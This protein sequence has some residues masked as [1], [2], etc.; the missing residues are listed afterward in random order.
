MSVCGFEPLDYFRNVIVAI[1]SK[2]GLM[3]GTL[4]GNRLILKY[5]PHIN[6]D[7]PAWFLE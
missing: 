2:F 1:E 5:L 7:L 4:P 3:Q 6:N